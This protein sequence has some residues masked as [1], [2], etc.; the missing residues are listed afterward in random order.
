[1]DSFQHV[2]NTIYAQFIEASRIQTLQSIANSA[3]S[4]EGIKLFQSYMSTKHIGP[5]LKSLHIKYKFP[6]TYPD[7]ITIGS[8]ITDISAYRFTMHHIIVSNKYEKVAAEG[9]GVIVSYDYR[10]GTKANTPAEIQQLLIKFR[11]KYYTGK[12]AQE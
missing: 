4:A 9:S 12:S 10:H 8:Q 3:Q 2:N 11:D 6:L 7:T 5:I 1:M